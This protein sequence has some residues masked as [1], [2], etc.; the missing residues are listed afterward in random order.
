MMRTGYLALLTWSLTAMILASPT[1]AVQDVQAPSRPDCVKAS[2]AIALYDR[3]ASLM[4][5]REIGRRPVAA[6]D[7]SYATQ[8]VAQDIADERCRRETVLWLLRTRRAEL[9]HQ[10]GG[11]IIISGPGLWSEMT[12]AAEDQMLLIDTLLHHMRT[13]NP[14]GGSP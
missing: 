10:M 1:L 3:F 8:F 14:P 9:Y 11:T 7:L 13:G 5:A 2:V 4:S 12:R 6:D